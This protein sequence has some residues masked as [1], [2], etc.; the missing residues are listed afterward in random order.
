MCI[1][2]ATFERHLAQCMLHMRCQ[3][4]KT[5]VTMHAAY[6][7]PPSKDTCHNACSEYRYSA[8][9]TAYAYV[10]PR[11]L[12]HVPSESITYRRIEHTC[13]LQLECK[14]EDETNLGAGRTTH[15]CLHQTRADLCTANSRIIRRDDHSLR[16][17][18]GPRFAAGSSVL[19][20]L[21]NDVAQDCDATLISAWTL[22]QRAAAAAGRSLAACHGLHICRID[23]CMCVWCACVCVCVCVCVQCM[24]RAFLPSNA[25]NAHSI[26]HTQETTCEP[27][28]CLD[29]VRCPL[30][31]C[32]VGLH[33]RH[34][35]TRMSRVN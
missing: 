13:M 21:S 19:E 18:G 1:C 16:S 7:M 9:F 14:P 23:M 8:L 4:R 26:P 2:D 20:R 30:S 27:P 31:T 28:R 25:C 24:Q 5:L 17:R 11:K 33:G 15:A 3:V 34:P 22:W 10:V 32:A 12:D 29:T 6:A 35:A